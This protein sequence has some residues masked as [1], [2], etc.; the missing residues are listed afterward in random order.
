MD[1]QP[2]TDA[3]SAAPYFQHPQPQ[4]SQPIAGQVFSYT[5]N[6]AGLPQGVQDLS[7]RVDMLIATH[8]HDGNQ[9]PR[10]NANTDIIGNLTAATYGGHVNSDG[11][12]GSYFPTNW[13]VT[14]TSTPYTVTH[15]L[16]TN[17]Y[18]VV[19]TS[20][21]GG[22]R[23]IEVETMTTASFKVYIYNSSSSSVAGAFNFVLT[24]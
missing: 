11:S 9:S 7:D 12:L 19:V 6:P 14:G 23:Y 22:V 1:K 17:L 3:E 24:T 5:A 21:D 8:V 18:S 4:S 2:K 20:V 16:N 15:N 13:T 10:I